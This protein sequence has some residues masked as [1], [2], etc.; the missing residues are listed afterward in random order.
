MDGEGVDRL[1]AEGCEGV[2]RCG[3]GGG[4]GF[5]VLEG[6]CVSFARLEI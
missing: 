2:W 4:Y 6:T 3:Y 5:D 1:G